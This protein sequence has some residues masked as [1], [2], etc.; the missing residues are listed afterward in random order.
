MCFG[1]VVSKASVVPPFMKDLS[2]LYGAS[3]PVSRGR[4]G[5]GRRDPLCGQFD[6]R[7]EAIHS[8][9]KVR[10]SRWPK[11]RGGVDSERESRQERD[12]DQ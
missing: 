8:R 6:G 5:G 12:L 3:S 4:D 1:E 11:S 2:V 10:V 9:K 7:R